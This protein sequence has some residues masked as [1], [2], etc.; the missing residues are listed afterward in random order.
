MPPI[1]I[2]V[3]F[4]PFRTLRQELVHPRTQYQPTTGKEWCTASHVLNA[5][6]PTLA[7]QVGTW[8]IIFENTTRLWKTET[9]SPLLLLSMFLLR[10]IKWI[11]Q[12]P[13]WLTPTT[14]PRP[15]A[16]WSPSTSSTTSPHSTGR[17]VLCQD[18]MLHYWPDCASI[19]CPPIIVLLLSLIFQFLPFN[20]SLVS[21]HCTILC[22]SVM[23]ILSPPPPFPF[24]F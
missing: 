24:V 8:T 18:S 1:A 23:L 15:A 9:Q 11:Y 14:T 2:Q 7:K 16:C 20:Y 5:P 6:A 22:D 17:E 13:W 21:I 3:F 10:T 4:C 19:W 12:R